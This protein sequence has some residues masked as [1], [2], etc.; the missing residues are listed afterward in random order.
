ML[1][2]T[3]ADGILELGDS[4]S[5]GFGP[6]TASVSQCLFQS[7]ARRFPYPSVPTPTATF[8]P[9]AAQK[10]PKSWTNA[11]P[12]RKAA[13]ISGTMATI[14]AGFVEKAT[15]AVIWLGVNDALAISNATETL[16]QFSTA[17]LAIVDDLF[18]NWGIPYAKMLWVG[19][20]ALNGTIT[21]Q[22]AQVDGQCVTNAAL[23]GFTFVKVSQIPFTGGNSIADGTH[24]TP[25]GAALL[26]AT[27]MPSVSTS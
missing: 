13:D 3:S 2:L 8:M 7:I 17:Q 15:A 1:A 12:G 4:L 9:R 27:V 16:P 18:T 23:R 5:A 14:R 24:P 25:Q 11:T 10:W 22:I 19:P 21:T 26:V 20:W 6:G